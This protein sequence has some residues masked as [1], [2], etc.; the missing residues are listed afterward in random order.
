MLN[1]LMNTRTLR[2]AVFAA[3]MAMLPAFVSV[4]AGAQDKTISKSE[5]KDL[6]ANA[7]TPVAHERIAQYF[8]AEATKYDADAKKHDEE[9]SDYASHPSN[10]A[11]GKDTVYSTDMQSHCSNLG[12]KL[13]E[14]AQE[15][16]MMAAGHREMAKEAAK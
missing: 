16:R 12:A 13:K 14:A 4:P 15:A 11:N 2:L 8:D 1:H 6:I 9:A 3:A 5:L 7:K 10:P